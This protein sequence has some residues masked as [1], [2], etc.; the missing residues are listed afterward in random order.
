[1]MNDSPLVSV[2]V[3]SYNHD[4]FIEATINSVLN[5]TYPKI[6][7]LI[8]DDGSTDNTPMII[9]KLAEW[10]PENI[11]SINQ[12]SN[13]GVPI[14]WNELLAH[15]NGEFLL[16]FASDDLLPPTAVEKRV[17]YLQEHSDVD[18]LVTDFDVISAEGKI[19]KGNQKLNLVPQFERFY[20]IDLNNL[21]SELLFGNFIPG[22][23]V[24]IRLERVSK[25]EVY[26]DPNCPNLSDYEL[27]LRLAFRYKW[28]YLSESTWIYRWHGNNFSSPTNPKNSTLTVISQTIYILSKQLL[29]PQPFYQKGITIKVINHQCRD[30]LHISK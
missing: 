12:G 21:Y 27:W 26:Q 8:I 18:V 1:M 11:T 3:P 5:Q 6:E 30:L 16:P 4:Q 19:L 7:L 9:E 25:N 22:G 24:F 23:A 2:I 14:R 28:A 29:L 13:K 15:V 17:K 10:Y 20:Q